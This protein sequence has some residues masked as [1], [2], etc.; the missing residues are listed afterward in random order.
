[1]LKTIKINGQALPLKPSANFLFYYRH[2]R[3]SGEDAPDFHSD[4][5]ALGLL[6]NWS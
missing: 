5:A 2:A 3:L 4:Q 6:L 1:M